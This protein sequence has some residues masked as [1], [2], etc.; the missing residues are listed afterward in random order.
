M[1]HKFDGFDLAVAVF[2]G[3]AFF[4]WAAWVTWGFR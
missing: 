2:V 3:A 1:R 4:A